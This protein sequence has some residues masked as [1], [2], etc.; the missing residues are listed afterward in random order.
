MCYET[1]APHQ[2]HAKLV[3]GFNETQCRYLWHFRQIYLQEG[4]KVP[5]SVAY[6]CYILDF[7]LVLELTK[8]CFS[9]RVFE[10]ICMPH[11]ELSWVKTRNKIQ[12]I[13]QNKRVLN[14]KQNTLTISSVWSKIIMNAKRRVNERKTP[15]KGNWHS[16]FPICCM[17]PRVFTL[18]QLFFSRKCWFNYFRIC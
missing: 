1:T 17:F 9:T 14:W 11:M 12:E 5:K 18:T 7:Q 2:L 15:S 16:E 4:T 13:K 10:F 8:G 6:N 3:N